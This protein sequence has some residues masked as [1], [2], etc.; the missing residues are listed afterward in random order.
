MS[1]EYAELMV[2]NL[3]ELKIDADLSLD[4]ADF[5]EQQQARIDELKEA[6]EWHIDEE[7]CRFDHNDNCQ[8]HFCFEGKRTCYM[9]ESKELLKPLPKPPEGK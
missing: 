8:E 9:Q 2:K 1:K 7:P 6:L 4:S 5:I 3:R